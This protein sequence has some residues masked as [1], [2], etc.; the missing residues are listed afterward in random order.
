M[1]RK[2]L[3]S[4]SNLI[5]YRLRSSIRHI[6]GLKQLQQYLMQK[7]LDGASFEHR[8]KGGP[9]DGLVYPVELPQ[10]KQIWLGN[11]EQSFSETL[12]AAIR[13]GDVCYD[14]GGY[15]G[16]FSGVMACQKAASVAVFE[17]L[18][19]NQTQIKKMIALNL[20]FT[21]SLFPYALADEAGETTFTVM[22]ESSMGKLG[23]STFDSGDQASGS[24]PV[25]LETIDRLIVGA[26]IQPA[27]L[28]KIDVE[29][30]EF[31]V[32]Q[33]SQNLVR[34]HHPTFYI[35]AHSRELARQCSE[36]LNSHGYTVTVL[37][38]G[39]PPDYSTEPVVCHLCAVVI[40]P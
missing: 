40:K 4:V 20:G 32:L 26:K 27:K 11:Y 15:R 2:L 3:Q 24:I 29:G 17:P 25:Q 21:I 31:L 5:P 13:P 1:L 6:P 23:K 9:A 36:F 8:I 19:D 34:E 12:A 14:I 30:A 38:T 16:F 22:P 28:I 35:E 18:P 7:H 37:Q 33:G 10:D 39:R